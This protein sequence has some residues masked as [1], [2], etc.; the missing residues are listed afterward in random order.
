MREDEGELEAARSDYSAELATLEGMIAAEPGDPELRDM[1]ADAHSGLGGIAERQGDFH[2]ALSQY[3]VQAAQFEHIAQAD[4]GNV[5]RRGNQAV[6]LLNQADVEMANGQLAEAA[7]RLRQAQGLLDA[8]VAHDASN[9]YWRSLSLTGRLRNA[10]LA[11]Q[12]GDM[13]DAGRGADEAL[14]K[15]RALSDTEPA[16]RANAIRLAIAWRL[17]AQIL[18]S[19]E[20]AGGRAAAMQAV[21]IA[22]KLLGG[23]R[24][25]DGDLGEFATAYVVAGEIAARAGDGGE[26]YRDWGRA[27]ELLSPRIPG[28][29]DWRLLDP[30]ARAAALTGRTA[31]ARAIIEEL[32]H[33]GYVPLDPWPALDRPAAA[34]S[35]VP[36]QQ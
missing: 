23:G 22:E 31:E 1:A 25:P 10:M 8:L 29:R 33:F 11:R 34:N 3:A 7:E 12:R 24:A 15:L 17:E 20:R 4:A 5:G 30:A 36:Q 6:A 21:E 18:F 13:D 32:H 9:L 26:A 19:A 28:S 35:T 2:E 16:D 14:S 27:A